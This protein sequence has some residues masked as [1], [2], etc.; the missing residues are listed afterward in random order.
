MP[1]CGVRTFLFTE[2]IAGLLA[3]L[4]MLSHEPRAVWIKQKTSDVPLAV[5]N[6]DSQQIQTAFLWGMPGK[7]V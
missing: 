3:V 7:A 6:L 4:Q 1:L 2:A 5:M